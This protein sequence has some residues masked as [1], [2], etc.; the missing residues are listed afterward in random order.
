MTPFSKAFLRLSTLHY[1]AFLKGVITLFHFALL[2]LF[3]RRYYAFLKGVISPFMH[4]TS[5]FSSPE[6]KAQVS[7]SD[8]NCPVSVVIVVVVGVNFSHFHLLLQNHWPNFNQTWHKASFG[9][10]DFSLFK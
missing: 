9:E 6:L 8:Q 3:K 1:Y 4:E 10:G 7:F 5:T 2:R